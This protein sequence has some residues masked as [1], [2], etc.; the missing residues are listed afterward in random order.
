MIEE[1]YK[2]MI[3]KV[4]ML[5]MEEIY[6]TWDEVGDRLFLAGMPDVLEQFQGLP[7]KERTRLLK[8]YS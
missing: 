1:D 7:A 5:L 3:L 4:K 6:P 8:K 2:K